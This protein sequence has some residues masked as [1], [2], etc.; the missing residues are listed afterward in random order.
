MKTLFLVH[1]SG[2]SS[3]ILYPFSFLKEGA[4]RPAENVYLSIQPTK[5]I[6]A[7]IKVKQV[8]KG[9]TDKILSKINKL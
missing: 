2:Q 1:R 3:D 4:G 6:K 7:N 8:G 9:V 5:T